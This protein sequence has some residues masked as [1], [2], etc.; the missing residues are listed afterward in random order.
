MLFLFIFTFFIMKKAILSALVTLACISAFAQKEVTTELYEHNQARILD[1]VSNAYVQPLV[2][3]LD[4][5]KSIG[6]EG[7]ISKEYMLTPTKMKAL[8]NKVEEIHKWGTYKM[9][10]DF[11]CDVLVAATFNIEQQPDGMYKLS[12]TGF[13]GKYKEWRPANPEDA[14]W[15]NIVTGI[16][17][18]DEKQQHAAIRQ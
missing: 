18:Q 14:W 16:G 13:A 3:K 2:V 9:S 6:V 4:I 1:A 7:R 5:D 11:G 15:I 8:G 10:K 12:V 17:R